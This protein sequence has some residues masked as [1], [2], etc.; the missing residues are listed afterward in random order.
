MK[1]HT[2]LTAGQT[3]LLYATS[4]RESSRS[5]ITCQSMMRMQEERG[6]SPGTESSRTPRGPARGRGGL[7]EPMSPASSFLDSN[8]P[9]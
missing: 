6:C 4:G 5:E 2:P 7:V 3:S 1:A 8:T 9:E